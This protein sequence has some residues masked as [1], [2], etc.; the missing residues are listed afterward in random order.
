VLRGFLAVDTF[1]ALSES[2]DRLLARLGAPQ[3]AV[4]AVVEAIES[5]LALTGAVLR[6]A[7]AD[8]HG[9]DRLCTVAAAVERLPASELRGL[10]QEI[11]TFDFFDRQSM[12]GLVPVR[13]RLHAL[14]TQRLA[15]RIACQIGHEHRDVLAAASLLHDVGKLV[16]IQAYSDYPAQILAGASTP[17]ERIRRERRELGVDHALVGG[18][19]LRRWRL[20]AALA[21]S[22]EHH[23][24]PAAE[25]DALLIGLADML[26][27]YEHGSPVSPG[28]MLGAAK[29]L[30]LHAPDLRQLMYETIGGSAK[31]KRYVRG[32]PLTPRE[33]AILQSLAAGRV[34]KQIAVDLGI[35]TS[36]VRT[37]LHNI[38]GKLD[39][40]DR[41][42][43]VLTAIRD[44]WI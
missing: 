22:V 42:Q 3:P 18:V 20:P 12:W 37:H 38:C 6:L 43:A 35:S 7:N 11:R 34:S 17:G 28:E 19:L 24:D 41:V 10:A 5:D 39:A 23:H 2:R 14:A 31:T 32:C 27:H 44:G 33:C 16:L 25:G 15:D 8:S 36:V 1:P 30:G 29:A 9:R 26:A 13:V 40:V 21:S 4:A